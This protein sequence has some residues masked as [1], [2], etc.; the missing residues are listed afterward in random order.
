M[1]REPFQDVATLAAGP[2]ACHA[3]RVGS[4]D[5]LIRARAFEKRARETVQPLTNGFAWPTLL[6][7]LGIIF[8]VSAVAALTIAG[9]LPYWAAVPINAVLLYFIFTPLHE[10]THGNIADRDRRFAWLEMLIGQ[11][12]G[13]LLLAPYPGYRILHLHHHAHTNDPEEDPDYWVKSSTWI[14]QLVRCLV[15]QPVYILHLRKIARDPR[16]KRAFV[17]ELAFV[18]SYFV[19]MGAAW[20]LGFGK[21]LMLL[22]ILPGYIGVVLVPA[23]FDW[24]V[25][26][27]HSERGRYTDTAILLF[28]PPFRTFMDIVF[29]GHT[30]HLLHHLYPRLPF[31]RYGGAWNL[32]KDELLTLG[33]KVRE[34]KF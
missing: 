17:W 16:S 14:G 3:H 28:P 19:I 10:A 25:H 18:A 26:H 27:P 4:D 34:F 23:M 11:A 13:F 12:S 5:F 20:G 15:I 1:D 8:G 30:Y 33:P 7:F 9:R 32:L 6:S 22:W 31:Y 21:E 24:P 2:A 29:C